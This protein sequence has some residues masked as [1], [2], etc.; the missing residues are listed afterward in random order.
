MMRQDILSINTHLHVSGAN[1][2]KILVA[3]SVSEISHS[4]AHIVASKDKNAKI[5][6]TSSMATGWMVRVNSLCPND[7]FFL[8]GWDKLMFEGRNEAKHY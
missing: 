2:D 1:T 6:S 4:F 8:G 5:H 3:A 7:L